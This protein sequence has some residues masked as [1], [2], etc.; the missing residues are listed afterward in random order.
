MLFDYIARLITNIFVVESIVMSPEATELLLVDD[1]LRYVL[2]GVSVILGVDMRASEIERLFEATLRAT[3]PH[4][5]MSFTARR[6]FSSPAAWT[7]TNLN[8]SGFPSPLRSLIKLNSSDW[9]RRH[10]MRP[11]A[12]RRFGGGRHNRQCNGP[13]RRYGYW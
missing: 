1:T 9:L 8:R 10:V 13:C 6:A 7:S 12:S 3:A 11:S 2:Y 4:N 5:R